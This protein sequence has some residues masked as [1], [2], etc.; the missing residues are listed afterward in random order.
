[1]ALSWP[2]RWPGGYGQA[3]GPAWRKCPTCNGTGI[4]PVLM[5][6]VC[7]KCHGEGKVLR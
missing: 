1:M 4:N 2:K 5:R 3:G 6:Y 7:P